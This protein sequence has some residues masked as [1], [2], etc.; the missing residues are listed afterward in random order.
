MESKKNP[1]DETLEELCKRADKEKD[2]E[3]LLELASRIQRL[4]DARRSEKTS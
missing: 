2:L 3:P 1:P 4:I